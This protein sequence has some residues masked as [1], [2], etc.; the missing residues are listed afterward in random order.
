[1]GKRKCDPTELQKLVKNV[2]VFMDAAQTHLLRLK[3]AIDDPKVLKE[4]R[5]GIRADFLE[6]ITDSLVEADE[7]K[8]RTNGNST[9]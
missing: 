5:D 4:Q 3:R 6:R 9:D 1:M 7:L 8:N 2:E